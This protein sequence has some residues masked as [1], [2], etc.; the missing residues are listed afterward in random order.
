MVG[1]L[2]NQPEAITDSLGERLDNLN[3]VDLRSWLLSLERNGPLRKLIQEEFN[4]EKR[5]ST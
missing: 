1:A 3:V 4:R 5:N 2:G